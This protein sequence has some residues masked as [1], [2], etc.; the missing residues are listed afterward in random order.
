MIFHHPAVKRVLNF[1]GPKTAK[2]QDLTYQSLSGD[3]MTGTNK[4]EIIVIH[5]KYYQITHQTHCV[6]V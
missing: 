1:A 5:A 6:L 4:L 2:I 3:V